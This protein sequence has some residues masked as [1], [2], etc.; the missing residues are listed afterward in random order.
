VWDDAVVTLDDAALVPSGILS[1]SSWS[2][3]HLVTLSIGLV[4]A[5]LLRLALLPTEGL[6]DDLDLFA[7]WIHR[8]ATDVPLGHAYDLPLTFPPVMTYLFRVMGA[9]QPLFQTVTDASDPLVRATIKLPASVADLGLAMGVAFLLR[10]RPG[11]AV[12]AAVTLALVPF[13]WYVSAWW[14]QFESI[15]VAFGLLAAILAAGGRWTLAAVAL[16][17]ALSTKPQALPFIVPFAGWALARRGPRRAAVA[18]LVAAATIGLLWLPFLPAG[19]PSAYLANVAAL[20]GIDYSVLSLRAWNFWWLVQE[21]LGG[22]DFIADGT[23]ILG[24]LSPRLL[25]YAMAGVAGLAVLVSVAR[26]PTDRALVLGLSAITLAAYLL[27]TTMHERYS[28]AAIVFLL[29]VAAGLGRPSIDRVLTA[30]W[31]AMVVVAS[32]NYVAAAPPGGVPGSLV[33]LDGPL[34]LAGSIVMCAAGA[35]VVGALV[36]RAPDVRA[37]PAA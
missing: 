22:G 29:P 30:T 24:P 11:V 27:M 14:G 33:P 5:A 12:A 4:A 10:R 34:G 37:A 28:F 16:G 8:L 3:R 7:M 18:G 19:G 23:A 15:Y 21:P 2:R 25:G 35:V 13:T 26:R 36:R 20:Q 1:G 9:A 32:L 31:V 6:R 17:L